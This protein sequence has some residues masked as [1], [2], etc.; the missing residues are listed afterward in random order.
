MERV[1]EVPVRFQ[2][3]KVA[4]TDKIYIYKKKIKYSTAILKVCQ[5]PRRKLYS[6]LKYRQS[7]KVQGPEKKT[8]P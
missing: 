4:A 8:V 1:Q 3:W 6:I 2:K 7:R 5:C